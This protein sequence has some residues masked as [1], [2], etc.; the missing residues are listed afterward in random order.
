MQLL[1]FTTRTSFEVYDAVAYAPARFLL[2]SKVN[3]S[4]LNEDEVQVINSRLAVSDKAQAWASEPGLPGRW[5][6]PDNNTGI[7]DYGEMIRKIDAIADRSAFYGAL[8]GVIVLAM[9]FRMLHLW[10]FQSQVKILFA[11]SLLPA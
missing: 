2:P 4:L 8:Q 6:L 1:E 11:G 7:E 3:V 5:K 9:I 10:N